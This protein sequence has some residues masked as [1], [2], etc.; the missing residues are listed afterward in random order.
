MIGSYL[1]IATL[2]NW[3]PQYSHEL[4]SD[5]TKEFWSNSEYRHFIVWTE[6]FQSVKASPYQYRIYLISDGLP[7][8]CRS[9]Q[10]CSVAYISHCAC[11]LYCQGPISVPSNLVFRISYWTEYR[12]DGMS[13][14][15]RFKYLSASLMLPGDF[16]N[17]PPCM[18]LHLIVT[19]TWRS[20]NTKP[21]AAT[22]LSGREQ[23]LVW[24]IYDEKLSFLTI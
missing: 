18:H 17:C 4:L 2:V 22:K 15:F 12:L 3:S 19:L 8:A 16:E 13:I 20:H 14:L 6:F 7:R 11:F 10:L 23:L 21:F 24:A 1:P 9:D 5:S